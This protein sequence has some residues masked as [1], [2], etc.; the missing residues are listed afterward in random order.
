MKKNAKVLLVI[1]AMV[2]GA[3][4]FAAPPHHGRRGHGRHHDRDGLDLANGIVDLVL[5]VVAPRP[6]PVVVQ[7]APV[8]VAPQPVVVQPAPVAVAPQPVVVQPAPVAVAPQPVVVQPAP[9]VVA[10]PPPVVIRQTPV[11]QYRYN[12]PAPR[13]HHGNHRRPGG[14]RR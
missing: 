8:A 7:P 1:V 2:L 14:H 9:V 3:G 12:Y 5:R 4:L 6:A 13:Y 11:V 10:P